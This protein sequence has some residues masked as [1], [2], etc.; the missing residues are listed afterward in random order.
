MILITD[1]K[2]GPGD[3]SEAILTATIGV[4]NFRLHVL[5]YEL[6]QFDNELI[7]KKYKVRCKK[8]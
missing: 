8:Y 3:L 6:C 1:F 5:C 2:S 7:E 4:V